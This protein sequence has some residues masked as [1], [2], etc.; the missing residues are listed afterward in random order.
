MPCEE[1]SLGEFGEL[2]QAKVGGRRELLS[3]TLGLTD[4]CNL[5]CVH[6]FVHEP[7]RDHEIKDREMTT[8]Q[9]MDILDQ[10]AEMGCLSLLITGGEPLVRDDFV[11]IYSHAKRRGFLIT[12]FTNGTLLTPEL[13]ELLASWYPRA[14][15]VTLYGLTRETYGAV[16]GNPAAFERCIKG[17][18][19]L[20]EAG[21]PL[22]LKAMAMRPT[23]AEIPAM[24]DYA[25]GL[26]VP[27][28]HDGMVWQPFFDKDLSELRLSPEEIVDL[29]RLQPIAGPDFIR[30]YERHNRIVA[31]QS[32]EE[33]RRLYQ[34]G[35]GHQSGYVD[36]YGV[37][38]IC[39]A[40]RPGIYDLRGGSLREGWDELGA[41]RA[42]TLAPR[43]SVCQ[44]CPLA[45]LCVPCPARAQREHGDPT[46]AVEVACQ[47]AHV[48]TE[49]LGLDVGS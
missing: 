17:V 10:L 24:Y 46:A 35:G 12:L 6:C 48:R 42:T 5:R 41:F 31:S 18:E 29:D 49:R 30:V 25:A 23:V 13:V 36:P 11:E 9:W 8:A 43:D 39:Q 20:V 7:A 16:T 40:V 1:L 21:L 4:R 32:E 14:I 28:R 22:R 15:E 3:A 19:M 38:G 34:C 45:G 47:V 2:L 44:T 27:F 37:L 33:R 26:G